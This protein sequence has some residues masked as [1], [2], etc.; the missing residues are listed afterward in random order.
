MLGDG[1]WV[2]VFAASHG[3]R[4]GCDGHPRRGSFGQT[5]CLRSA[6]TIVVLADNWH[7]IVG[8]AA[9]AVAETSVG[10]RQAAALAGSDTRPTLSS[11][12]CR[13]LGLSN[14]RPHLAWA[15]AP[16]VGGVLR[17]LLGGCRYV[18]GHEQDRVTRDHV[19]TWRPSHVSAGW[20][21]NLSIARIVGVAL[22]LCTDGDCASL[23]STPGPKAAPYAR[24][25][26]PAAI[27]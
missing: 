6:S 12:L 23:N 10:R 4:S 17:C 7:S 11:A 16:T 24:A 21:N 19:R 3:S 14:R 1:S 8:G 13:R 9:Y 27:S 22:A 20:V 18:A 5:G 26:N 25:D 2:T 15:T